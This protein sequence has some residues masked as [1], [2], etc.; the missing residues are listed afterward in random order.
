VY[1]VRPSRILKTTRI[2]NPLKWF[3]GQQKNFLGDNKECLISSNFCLFLSFLFTLRI[4]N[5]NRKF[6][7]SSLCHLIIACNNYKLTLLSWNTTKLQ[8]EMKKVPNI[9]SEN[10]TKFKCLVPT[11]TNENY[12]HEE[13]KSS[14][15]PNRGIP[16]TVQVRNSFLSV[17]HLKNVKPPKLQIHLLSIFIKLV[18][19]Y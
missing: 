19:L 7:I 9:T 5:E 11:L 12:V 6:W 14:P 10:V 2:S 16:S 1:V 15:P 8:N 4:W 17:R 18:D 3:R 13:I